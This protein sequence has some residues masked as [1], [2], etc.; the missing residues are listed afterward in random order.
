MIGDYY[1]IIN[2]RSTIINWIDSIRS[3][4]LSE[5]QGIKPP[6]IRPCKKPQVSLTLAK[7]SV[8]LLP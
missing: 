8:V 1:A 4:V 7:A 5:S 6:K 3:A 2:Q